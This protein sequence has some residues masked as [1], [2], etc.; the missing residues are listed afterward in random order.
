MAQELLKRLETAIANNHKQTYINTIFDFTDNDIL[1]LTE[2]E[3]NTIF[4]SSQKIN[5]GNIGELFDSITNEGY[6]CLNN[7]LNGINELNNALMCRFYFGLYIN[8]FQIKNEK[9]ASALMHQGVAYTLLSNLGVNS[10]S[11]LESAIELHK[12]ARGIFVPD[13]PDHASAMLNEATARQILA[14][15]GVASKINLE[16]GIELCKTASV[17]STA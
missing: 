15:M 17:M 9:Y 16:S 12:I 5:I 6:F 11:N 7:A 13:S 3:I 14:E 4:T 10:L 8:L 2:D 1:S